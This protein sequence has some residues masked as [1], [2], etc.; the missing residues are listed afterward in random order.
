LLLHTSSHHVATTLTP[1]SSP[2]FHPEVMRTVGSP[3]ISRC[4]AEGLPPR[5]RLNSITGN[6][7]SLNLSLVCPC[8]DDSS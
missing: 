4:I 1:F 7:H 8:L 3:N 2:L 6:W 5:A